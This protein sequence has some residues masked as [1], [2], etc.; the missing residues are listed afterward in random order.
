MRETSTHLVV[1]TEEQQTKQELAAAQL[2]RADLLAF[3]SRTS[4]SMIFLYAA[5]LDRARCP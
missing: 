3:L 1:Q 2:N 4:T 5:K